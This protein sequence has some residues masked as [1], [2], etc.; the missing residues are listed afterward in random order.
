MTTPAQYRY[1]QINRLLL[2]IGGV[3][4]FLAAITFAGSSIF[5]A[6]AWAWGFG[7]FAAWCLAG[8]V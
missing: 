2:V 5:G 7:G 8:A 1:P 3:L 4:F 6:P